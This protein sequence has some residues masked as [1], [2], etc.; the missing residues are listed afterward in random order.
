MFLENSRRPSRS[1][2]SLVLVSRS[3]RPDVTRRQSRLSAGV[4]HRISLA[5]LLSFLSAT[6]SQAAWLEWAKIPVKTTD[7]ARCMELAFAAA[8]KVPLQ[9]IQRNSGEV[10]G[11]SGD[12]HASMT[13][14]GRG[15]KQPTLAIVIVVSD[16]QSNAAALKERLSEH[17]SAMPAK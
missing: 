10:S 14:V 12:S 3:A 17:L 8:T 6:T 15:G 13:C 4:A 16:T 5:L 7:E 11:T 2:S 1:P 9:N